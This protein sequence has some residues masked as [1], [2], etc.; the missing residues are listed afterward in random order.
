MTDD[1]VGHCFDIDYFMDM[2]QKPEHDM[3]TVTAQ[4]KEAYK[5]VEK[6]V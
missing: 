5:D 6:S 4:Y 2:C 1:I 3:K